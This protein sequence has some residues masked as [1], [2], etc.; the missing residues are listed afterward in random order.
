M[1][2]KP[3]LQGFGVIA[4]LMTIIPLLAADMWWIRIFDYPHIQL[5]LL[6]LTA[7]AAYFLRFEIKNWKDY[8]FMIVLIACFSYQFAKIYPYTPFSPSEVNEPTAAVNEDTGFILF[9]SNVLQK[10]KNPALLLEELKLINPDIAVF[11]ETNERWAEDIRKGIGKDY[12]YRIEAPID[13]TYGMILYSKLKLID[14]EVKF[15]VDD[16]IPSIHS[17][18]ELLSGDIIQLH[19]IHP[20]PPMP[21]HNPSSSDRDAE[22]MKIAL[23]ALDADKPVVVLGDFNDVAWS[24]S[25]ELFKEIG[26]LLDVRVGRNFY[27]TFDAM[28]SIMRWSLDH[29]FVSEEFRVK[30]IAT[31]K[32][33]DSDHFPFYAHL[34]LQP[35]LAE[36]QKPNL[37]SEEQIEL[38]REQIAREKKK[39]KN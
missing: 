28:S 14:P 38:A 22:M 26:G 4:V 35:E 23:Q 5:T 17:E 8:A 29:I 31:G 18:I 24:R 34:Y 11:T 6:T 30:M 12:E 27:N 1:S 39:D 21:Q 32:N 2:L 3:F 7:I 13:N 37:A 19:A 36:Q 33:I 16:S 10:N 25:T 9:T 20:T 15:L